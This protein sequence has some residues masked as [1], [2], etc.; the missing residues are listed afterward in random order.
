[1]EMLFGPGIARLHTEPIEEVIELGDLT[2]R[3][4]NSQRPRGEEKGP[5]Y[6]QR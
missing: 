3:P 1:M 6:Q 2:G 5:G 4:P